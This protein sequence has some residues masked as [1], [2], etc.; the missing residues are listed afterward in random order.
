MPELPEVETVVRSLRPKLQGRTVEKVRI[1]HEDVIHH[2]ADTKAFARRLQGRQV[3]ELSRRGKYICVT[4]DDGQLLAAHLRMTGRLLCVP[5]ER[6]LL[7]HTHVVM[8]LS[9]GEELRYADV[10]R[11]GG[12]WLLEKGEP[13]NVTGMSRLG[14]EPFSPDFS[15]E[16]LRARLGRRSCPVKNG[17]LDQSVLA[18][19]GNIYADETLFAAG[20]RPDR[21][22]RS[23]TEAEWERIAAAIPPIL[24][25]A[26][27]H[28][29]TTFSDFLDGEGREGEN[30]GFLQAYGRYGKPC[31]RCGA[32]MER[33]RIGGRGTCFCPDCQR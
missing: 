23:L 33:T 8:D 24:E 16:Y 25:S 27:A 32:V 21:L 11:F 28:N 20:V 30:A 13:D 9:G 2:P 17:I 29:G 31:L 15:A 10:R 26:I 22:C 4:L 7:P 19:L 6:E 1:L 3:T 12:F 14:P 5:P 18:G